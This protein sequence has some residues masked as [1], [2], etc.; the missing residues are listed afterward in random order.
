MKLLIMAGKKAFTLIEIL[1]VVML[2]AVIS[3]LA[4]PKLNPIYSKIELKAAT[5][6]LAY[7]MRYA[8]SR[9]V[10]RRRVIKLE[11]NSALDSYHIEEGQ[12]GD[13]QGNQTQNY[14]SI[15]GRNGRTYQIPAGIQVTLEDNLEGDSEEML[16][17][18]SIGFYS[19]GTIEKQRIQLCRG[20]RC[21]TISTAEQRGYVRIFDTLPES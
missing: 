19:D 5:N 20:Q 2:L 3:S 17:N 12:R 4:I 6:D 15:S 9:A 8:Q 18:H 10:T 21:H 16:E 11:F 13:D 7:L 1:L 14:G